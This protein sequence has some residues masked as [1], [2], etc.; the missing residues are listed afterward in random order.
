MT[1]YINF[2]AW[3]Q[4]TISLVCFA[5]NAINPW[6]QVIP[7]FDRAM[8]PRFT[9]AI[10]IHRNFVY[11]SNFGESGRQIRRPKLL[12]YCFQSS[13]QLS[14]KVVEGLDST[15]SKTKA[16]L[17]PQ[18]NFPGWRPPD[19]HADAG[20]EAHQKICQFLIAETCWVFTKIIGH[21]G[22]FRWLGPNVRWQI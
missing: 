11:I 14:G 16:K 9:P 5:N 12:K 7:I 1:W 6:P 8:P 19:Q 22:H 18:A 20:R 4:R 17:D 15:A 21:I 10:C 13:C 2:L 3:R